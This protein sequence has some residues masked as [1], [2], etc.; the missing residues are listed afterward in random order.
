[1]SRVGKNPITVPVGVEVELNGTTVEVKGPKGQLS[2][3]IPDT[4]DHTLEDG[5][6]TFTRRDDRP[7]SRANHGLARALVNNMVVGVTQGFSKHLEVEGTG[8]KWEVKGKQ[9]VLN[10]GYSHPVHIDIPDGIEVEINGIRCEVRGIDKQKVGFI[11][12]Q[13]RR[14]RPPE[15]YK[16]KGIRFRGEQIRRKAG[17][18]GA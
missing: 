5:V 9:V 12:A 15:P 10:M 3:E 1:M 6:L 2:C 18:A 8:Y 13:I 17:K 4:V 11:T 14:V 16:G 7:Q